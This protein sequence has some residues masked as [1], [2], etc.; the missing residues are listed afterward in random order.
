MAIIISFWK[1]ILIPKLL[2]SLITGGA[3]VVPLISFLLSKK[4]SN[5]RTCSDTCATGFAVS[6]K[7]VTIFGH[8]KLKEAERSKS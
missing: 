7:S 1:N 5:E 3:A 6:K 4:Q 8:L 2:V